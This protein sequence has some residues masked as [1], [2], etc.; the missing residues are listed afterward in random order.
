[1]NIREKQCIFLVVE[2][3]NW[4]KEIIIETLYWATEARERDLEQYG[5]RWEVSTNASIKR[6]IKANWK[7][8]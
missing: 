3:H 5:K 7:N 6:K 8:W 4:F 1:M 2:I